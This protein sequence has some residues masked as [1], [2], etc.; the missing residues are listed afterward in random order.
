MSLTVDEIMSQPDLWLK[1]S[2]RPTDAL[3]DNDKKVAVIGCGTSWF[4]AQAYCRY[5]QLH[6][7]AVSDA[8]TATEFPDFYDYDA[9]I[10]L[11][12]SGTTSEIVELAKHCH[13]NDIHAILITAVAGGPASPYV[14]SEIVFEEADEESVVQ[15]RFATTALAWLLSSLDFD[16]K[17][18]AEDCR[19][20]LEAEI[21]QRWVE[22][23]QITF[24]GMGWTIGVANEAALKC[25]EASQSWTEA[26]SAM[27]YRHGPISIAQPGRLVWVFGEV[28]AGLDKQV[29]QTG[30]EMVTSEWNPLAH[31]VLAQRVAVARAEN[32]GLNPDT[33]RHLTRSVILS[34]DE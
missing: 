28:P 6:C 30:A 1:L 20:A 13:E 31:L 15:T 25:R 21:P 32:R 29:E 16:V 24:L 26:Y 12:R 23:D 19:K 9:L 14:D 11:S 17:A 27:E 5:R 2:T 33:P 3:P 34:D 8:Y 10:L 7:N 22:A 4:M 18:A